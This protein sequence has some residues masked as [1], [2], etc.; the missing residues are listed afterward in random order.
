MAGLFII[1]PPYFTNN[2]PHRFFTMGP[3]ERS[4]LRQVAAVREAL[5]TF[6]DV[7]KKGTS[8]VI[9]CS[10]LEVINFAVRSLFILLRAPT[11]LLILLGCP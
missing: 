8:R 7:Q 5:D 10:L 2:S 4:V 3:T 6:L 11:Y 1:R 9:H